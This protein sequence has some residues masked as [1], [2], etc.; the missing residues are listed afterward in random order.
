MAGA[1]I[2]GWDVPLTVDKNIPEDDSYKKKLK[3]VSELK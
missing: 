2:K 3:G 1:V